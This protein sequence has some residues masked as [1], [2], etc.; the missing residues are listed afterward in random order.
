LKN[1]KQVNGI[2]NKGTEIVPNKLKGDIEMGILTVGALM[3]VL[4]IPS[5]LFVN[6]VRSEEK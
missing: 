5:G 6:W 1:C 4:A 3:L 2:V